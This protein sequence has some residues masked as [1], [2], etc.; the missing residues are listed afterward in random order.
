MKLL[1]M[2]WIANDWIIPRARSLSKADS[3]SQQASRR[4][5]TV[6]CETRVA[7]LPD[8]ESILVTY[9]AECSKLLDAEDARRQSVEGRLTSIMGLSSI[10]ATIV[11]GSILAQ[12][13]GTL[14]VQRVWLRWVLAI[15]ALY[16]ALQLCCAIMAAL[17]GLERQSYLA[18][19]TYDV[20]PLP[21]GEARSPYLHRQ[22]QNCVSNLA[23]HRTVNGKKVTQMA[24][25]HC[26]MKNFLWFLLILALV[27]AYGGIT[28]PSQG[29]DLLETLRRD[30][31]V[32]ELLRGPQGPAGPRGEPCAQPTAPETPPLRTR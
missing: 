17:R 25:A 28:S 3:E 27:G 5:E 21:S 19:S 16:L 1:D 2:L 11:F 12:A 18:S 26:A 24:I 10:G 32:Q 7:A 4:E 29:N 30:R 9:L 22:I 6:E 31:Q 13:G 23:D 20:F 15:G 8:E 14:H